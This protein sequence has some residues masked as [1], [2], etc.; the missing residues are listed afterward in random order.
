MSS[1]DSGGDGPESPE[2]LLLKRERARLLRKKIEAVRAFG[3]RYYRPHPKQDQFH[4]A[5]LFSRRRMCRSGNRFGKSTMG[6]A[7]DVA[8]SLGYRPWLRK[9]DPAYRGGIPQHPTRG[10][11]ITTDW[12]TV[13]DVFTGDRGTRG[14]FWMF[15]PEGEVKSSLRN[16]S[17]SIDTLELRNGSLIKFNT[18]KAFMTNPQSAESK[19]WDWIH[20]DEPCP[21]KMYKASA[22][23]LMDRRGSAWF[24]LTPLREPWITDLFFPQEVDGEPNLGTWAIDGS[25]YD[26]PY[27]TPEAIREFEMSL[28]AEERECRIHGKPLH[29]AGLVY[30]EFDRARHVLTHVPKGWLSYSQPPRDYSYYV[31][32]DPHPQTPHAVLFCAVSPFG[33]RFYYRDI[34]FRGSIGDLCKQIHTALEGRTVVRFRLDPLGF[35]NNPVTETSMADEFLRYGIMVEK[36]PKCLEA[37]IIKVKGELK[38]E[39]TIY[40][41]P[42]CRRTLWE[43]VR[44]CWDEKDNKPID[45]DD[46]M[47]ENL[48]RCEVENPVYVDPITPPNLSREIEIRAPEFDLADYSLEV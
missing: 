3:L 17:G 25:T 37:G 6:V 2:L 45:K 38:K 19:D 35:I 46:H 43:I 20:V 26:N 22:R 48:Y 40:F 16:H 18:V 10:L 36:A 31:Y 47:M 44:Y 30:K 32:I 33:Q 29:L 11:V 24:T 23:G 15:I 42:E 21:E 12:E 13:D 9:D 39:D 4:R 28:S 34:F 41:T 14:K 5:A 8:W 27:L 7:E 1:G